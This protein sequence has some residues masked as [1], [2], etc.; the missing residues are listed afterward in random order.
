MM[1]FYR[2]FLMLNGLAASAFIL[3]FSPGISA[4]NAPDKTHVESGYYYTIQKGDTLWDVS[5]HFFDSPWQWP[6]LWKENSQI[7]NP[8]RIEPGERI[9]LHREKWNAAN[10]DSVIK[11]DPAVNTA[12]QGKKPQETPPYYLYTAMDQV[13]FIRKNP[14][15]SDGVILKSKEDKELI[16]H[17]DLVYI[18]PE[19][20]AAETFFP[21]SRHTVY[22]RLSPVKD[23]DAISRIGAQHY[24]TGA[25]RVLEKTPRFTVASVIK[26]FRPILNGDLLM[27]HLS[28]SSKI[29]IVKSPEQLHGK[30]I[31]SEEHDAVMAENFIAFIDKGK[32]DGVAAGQRYSIYYQEKQ[33]DSRSKES[34]LLSTVDIGSLLVLHTEQTTSTV[35]ITHSTQSIPPGA[36]IRS[37]SAQSQ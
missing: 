25:V 27:P 22:R 34:M 21:G 15:K 33:P 12:P 31:V 13:G 7:P 9:R 23:R 10:P 36:T 30:I 24:L 28:R 11:K 3:F 5:E 32:I 20:S 26:S 4:E 37:V 16:S 19:K 17:G 6:D 1:I 18:Q 29:P 35:L 2:K 14:G 8:H